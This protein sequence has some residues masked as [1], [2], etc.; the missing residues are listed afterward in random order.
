MAIL[1][2]PPPLFFF[3]IEAWSDSKWFEKQERNLHF[4]IKTFT[5]SLSGDFTLTFAAFPVV[6]KHY[7]AVDLL[8]ILWKCIFLDLSSRNP[9]SIGVKGQ[10]CHQIVTVYYW[11]TGW[12]RTEI[13]PILVSSSHT[14]LVYLE[15][16][17][18]LNFKFQLL[19]KPSICWGYINK[20][21]ESWGSFFKFAQRLSMPWWISPSP[22]KNNTKTGLQMQEINEKEHLWRKMR[23]KPGNAEGAIQQAWRS[24]PCE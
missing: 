6:L 3:L 8:A 1:P 24:H 19:A 16:G 15:K 14:L 23:R 21:S 5:S 11:P 9:L 22:V 17:P 18:P 20:I 7:H 12:V 4:R 2:P 10:T 13:Q